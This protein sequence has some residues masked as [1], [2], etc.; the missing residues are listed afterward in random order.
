MMPKGE[1]TGGA[2]GGVDETGQCLTCLTI[3]QLRS[4]A[5]QDCMYSESVKLKYRD[6]KDKSS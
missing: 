1:F 2:T 4:A 5:I 3:T 6:C